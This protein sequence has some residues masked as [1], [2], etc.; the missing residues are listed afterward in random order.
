MPTTTDGESWTSSRYLTWVASLTPGERQMIER[1]GEEDA[2]TLFATPED[3]LTA[4]R[5][6]G[7]GR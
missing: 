4:A 3:A 2:M 7:S 6:V 5:S 1:Y